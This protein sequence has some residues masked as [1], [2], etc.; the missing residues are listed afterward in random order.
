MMPVTPCARCRD[1]LSQGMGEATLRELAMAGLLER[2]DPCIA[3]DPDVLEDD[4]S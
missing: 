3:G 4:G 2:C 1:L